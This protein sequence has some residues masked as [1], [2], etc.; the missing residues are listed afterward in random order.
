[1]KIEAIVI[2]PDQSLIQA[3]K[4]ATKVW[5]DSL[6]QDDFVVMRNS[7]AYKKNNITIEQ[8]S[9]I[10]PS[11]QINLK[12]GQRLKVS[13]DATMRAYFNLVGRTSYDCTNYFLSQYSEE[14]REVEKEYN[15]RCRLTKSILTNF[16]QIPL[17]T[18]RS[19]QASLIDKGENFQ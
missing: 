1:M 10:T 13:Y 6:K 16:N 18:L 2:I 5:V 11:G 4:P 19:L 14:V 15:E 8:I 7:S 12:S 9:K 17:E 3:L